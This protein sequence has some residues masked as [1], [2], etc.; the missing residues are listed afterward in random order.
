MAFGVEFR[1][2]P[3]QGPEFVVGVCCHLCERLGVWNF[4]AAHSVLVPELL[5][6][7]LVRAPAPVGVVP[8]DLARELEVQAMK[9]FRV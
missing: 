9:L 5:K 7:P 6:V 1:F 3:S 8:A 2:I 4:K